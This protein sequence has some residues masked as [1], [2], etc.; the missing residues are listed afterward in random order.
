MAMMENV[1]PAIETPPQG[2]AGY[3]AD[4]NELWRFSELL[5]RLVHLLPGSN[6][7]HLDP[8]SIIKELWKSIYN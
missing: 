6:T 3:L 2:A 5:K 1:P 7:P 8:F 4:G